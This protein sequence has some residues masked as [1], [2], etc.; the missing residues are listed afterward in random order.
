MKTK[1]EPTE[2]LLS[3]MLTPKQAAEFAGVDVKT[4]YRRILDADLPAVRF[5]P[6][7][8]RI[9]REDLLSLLTPV[10]SGRETLKPVGETLK[11]VGETLKPGRETPVASEGPHRAARKKS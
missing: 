6:R 2:G 5:G 8:M 3:P 1:Q 7:C 4:I 10:T 11:P 9:R